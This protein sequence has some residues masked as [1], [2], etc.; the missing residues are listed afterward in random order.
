[1]V[2]TRVVLTALL[3]LNGPMPIGKL[4]EESG[5]PYPDVRQHMETNSER[6]DDGNFIDMY[7]WVFR[8]QDGHA[9]RHWYLTGKEQL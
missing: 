2:S 6:D 7:A 1:M 4:A 9:V 3:E 8:D 5:L